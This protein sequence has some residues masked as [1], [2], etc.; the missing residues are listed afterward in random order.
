MFGHQVEILRGKA[1]D[2]V[3]H[4]AAKSFI[5]NLSI[6]GVRGLFGSMA[7]QCNKYVVI[8]SN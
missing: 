4:N 2:D 7:I 8:Y 1:K 6:T 5:E 3:L